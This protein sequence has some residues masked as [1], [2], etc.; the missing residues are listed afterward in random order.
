MKYLGISQEKKF[1]ERLRENY[2]EQKDFVIISKTG[3]KSKGGVKEAYYFI[4]FDC[5]EKKCMVSNTEKGKR[6]KRLFSSITQTHQL[7]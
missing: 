1:I 4:S 5:F 3:V 6:S 7:L 2:K